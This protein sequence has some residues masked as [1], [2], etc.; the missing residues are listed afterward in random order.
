MLWLQIGPLLTRI[1]VTR[2]VKDAPI[3]TRSMIG[4]LE[5]HD[6]VAARAALERD[7]TQSTGRVLE[8]LT[9]QR[10]LRRG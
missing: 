7:L 8:E 6:G 5:R 10:V 1:A 2:A 4:A 9:Q 3:P